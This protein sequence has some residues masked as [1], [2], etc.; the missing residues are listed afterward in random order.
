MPD[1]F[2]I[3]DAFSALEREIATI[4]SPR[5]AAHAV[6]SARRRRR[7]TYGAI[8]AVAVLAVGGAA[9]SQGLGGRD[10]AVG[11]SDQLPPPAELTPAALSAATAGWIDGWGTPDDTQTRSL[12]SVT[13]LRH[14][15]SN[16][17]DHAIRG[18]EHAYGAGSTEITYMLGMEFPADRVDAAVA[19]MATKA[20]SCNPTVTS[21]KTYTDGSQA[22]FYQLPAT[23]GSGDLEL[24]TAQY[25]D[26]LAL[27]VMAG[28]TNEPPADVVGHVDDLLLG[29]L[30]V[31]TTFNTGSSI[32]VPSGSKS[33]SS[34]DFGSVAESDFAAAL[35]AWP[36]EWQ[37]TGTKSIGKS[38]PCIGDWTQGSSSGMGASLGSNGEQ[39]FFSFDSVDS[40][41][42]SLQA[43]ASNLQACAASPATVRTV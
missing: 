35:G 5:G 8:A 16:A 32:G 36:N 33:A 26:R 21:T 43:L 1:L 13:C 42:A 9:I 10:G 31:D 4:S 38:L 12:A 40:A 6:A 34:A 2:D 15:N 29:A 30:Q 7:T 24:W 39:D 37:R 11:P 25:G 28:T 17:F 22:T 14:N 41:R 3:D 27:A 20:A 19:A 23:S 18:G